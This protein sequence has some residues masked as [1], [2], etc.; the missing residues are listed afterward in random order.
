MKPSSYVPY[1]L[2]V[3]A[4]EQLLKGNAYS[5]IIPGSDILIN[6]SAERRFFSVVS[7][8][9]KILCT[10]IKPMNLRNVNIGVGLL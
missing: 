6:K 4:V 9:H 1:H 3:K 5:L 2:F 8:L 7:H 10:N